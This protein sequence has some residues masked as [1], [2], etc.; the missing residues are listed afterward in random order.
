MPI[1]A[2]E[3]GPGYGTIDSG[4]GYRFLLGPLGRD[5]DLILVDNRG[6]G[7]SGAI[8]CKRLQAGK[9]DY[10]RN[11]GRCARQLGRRRGRVRHRRRRR[12]PRGRSSTGSRSPW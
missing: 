12:R 7:R 10:T 6:T 3:G 8:D 1:V 4:A 9:G 11:V 5:H 2:A